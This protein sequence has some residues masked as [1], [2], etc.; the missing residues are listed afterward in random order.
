MSEPLFCGFDPGSRHVGWCLLTLDDGL[1]IDLGAWR[2]PTD[3]INAVR[4]PALWRHWHEW[5][6][7][8]QVTAAAIETQWVGRN[9]Q[10]AL[11]IGR[12]R[13]WLE[14]WLAASGVTELL[15]ISPVEGKLALAGNADADK[16]AMIRV[17]G[18]LTSL[19]HIPTS[20]HEHAA[21]AL[22][23]A[24]AGRAQWRMSRLLKGA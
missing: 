19:D 15:G 3:D 10:S 12:A 23:I 24:L 18:L 17:A 13:G 7:R 5:P 11:T 8:E 2:L 21:D 14:A 1:I 9:A 4:L 22:G 16:E 20:L 6:Y